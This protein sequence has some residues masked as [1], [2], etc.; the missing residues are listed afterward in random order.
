MQLH[1]FRVELAGEFKQTVAFW[2]V[3]CHRFRHALRERDLVQQAGQVLQGGVERKAACSE[4]SRFSHQA[5]TILCRQG[6]KQRQQISLVDDSKHG[7]RFGFFDFAAAVGD[8]LV[9]Q[10]ERVTHAAGGGAREQV[11]GTGFEW[12]VFRFQHVFQMAGNVPR[13]HLLE[14]ELQAARQHCD[15]HFLRVGG[16]ENENNV[17][18]RFFQRLQHGV[19]R[20]F[21]QHVHFVDDVDLVTPGGGGVL[22]VF[23][24]VAHVVDAGVGGGV[25]FDQVD[26]AAAVNLGTGRADAAGLG[27]GVVVV[28]AVEAFG[29]N[30]RQRGLADAACASE[31]IGVMQAAL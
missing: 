11:Q 13:W 12:D 30:A 17:A 27:A 2:G 1:A 4:F 6:F 24:D 23:D 8:G 31:Q 10:R 20:V 22:R 15:R 19:E 21:R 29:E 5:R 28:R 7:A 25:D 18:R 26:E 9:G 14:V 16:G 3:F